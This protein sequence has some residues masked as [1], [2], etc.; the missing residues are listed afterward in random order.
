MS[1]CEIFYGFD[2]VTNSINSCFNLGE[3][4]P[5]LNGNCH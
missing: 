1:E 4:I 5:I 3:T 2:M